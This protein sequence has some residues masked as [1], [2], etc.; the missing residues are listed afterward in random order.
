[1]R[2]FIGARIYL[3]QMTEADA[4]ERYVSWLNDP[5]VNR[6]LATKSATVPELRAY[7]ASKNS[8]PDTL[9]FGIFLKEKDIH[10]GTIKLEPIDAVNKKAT[11]A[12]M[13]GDKQQWGQG[14]AREALSLLI[15]YCFKDLQLAEVNL[16]VVAQ[17]EAAVQ[18][19]V[20]LGFK[21]VQREIGAVHYP[22][23]VFDQVT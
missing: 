7:I 9:L 15:D 14:L 20:K 3:R 19:Y 17:N 10:I 4:T 12:I 18:T 13:L 1:M 11:V 21:E 22:N 16:G 2:T 8:Q 23:G 5:E 6:Y